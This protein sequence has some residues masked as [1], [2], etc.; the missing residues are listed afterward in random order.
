LT[1]IK[2][3]D[4][5]AFKIGRHPRYERCFP[6]F[7]QFSFQENAMKR[8]AG[9][10]GLFVFMFACSIVIAADSAK[11]KEKARAEI[12]KASSQTLSALYKA[13][14]SAKK[15]IESAAGY[16]TFS[17]FGMKILVAGS[18]TGKGLVVKKGSPNKETF[19]KMVEAQAGIGFGVKKFR[20]VFVFQNAADLDN[21][22][23][24]G[25]QSSAQATAAATDGGKGGAYAG[26]IPVS[27]GVWMYQL[28]DKGIAAEA[29]VKGTKYYKDDDLN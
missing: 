4:C 11:D 7:C 8:L 16:A 10:F 28:T 26:A 3:D 24:S 21:F 25:W 15:A 12:R 20:V 14:P 23:N 17:N 19:M 13:Q 9:I 6:S 18:G 5:A 22:V 1:F 27:N 2:R 29:T